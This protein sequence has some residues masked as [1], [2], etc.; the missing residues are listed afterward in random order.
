M[1]RPLGTFYCFIELFP[2]FRKYYFVLL[3]PFFRK[4]LLPFILLFFILLL[5]VFIV[6]LDPFSPPVRFDRPLG[7]FNILWDVLQSFWT[8]YRPF[9][10]ARV[11]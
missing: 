5:D 7:L 9:R 6:L 3:N 1:T 2:S 10:P 4:F 11:F 8:F